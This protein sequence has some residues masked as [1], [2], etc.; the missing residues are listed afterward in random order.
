MPGRYDDEPDTNDSLLNPLST[1][2]PSDS[3]SR[4]HRDHRWSPSYIAASRGGTPL[5]IIKQ[6]VE[7][8]GPTS[9]TARA[10]RAG[11]AETG[12]PALKDRAC[13]D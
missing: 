11:R 3:K 8:H 10:R 4:T 6:Y 7:N 5:S 2:F 1:A 12:D 9:L 13:A